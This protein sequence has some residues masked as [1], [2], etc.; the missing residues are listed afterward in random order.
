MKD[1]SPLLIKILAVG[2]IGISSIPL[3]AQEAKVVMVAESGMAAPNPVGDAVDVDVSSPRIRLSAVSGELQSKL[4]TKTARIGDSVILK[5]KATIKTAD[6]TTIPQ[7]ARLVGKITEVQAHG[8]TNADSRLAIQ[9]NRAE[10]KSGQG[11]AIRSVI[12]S[13]APPPTAIVGAVGEEE[14]A[15]GNAQVRGSHSASGSERMGGPVAGNAVSSEGGSVGNP[16]GS[17]ATAVRSMADGAMSSTNDKWVKVKKTAAVD[18]QVKTVTPGTDVTAR[19]T[20]IRG[21]SLSADAAG[22]AASADSPSGM[23]F[24]AKQNIHLDGGTQ[25]VLGVATAASIQ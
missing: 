12:Q 14:S 15:S 21:V 5:T 16:A 22:S 6:G 7:G 23:L 19:R 24:A 10:L 8:G 1:Y 2:F 4:D 17:S 11:L 20:D 25:M 9:F 18:H 3:V 13:V